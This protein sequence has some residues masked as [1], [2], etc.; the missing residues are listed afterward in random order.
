MNG[1]TTGL[2]GLVRFAAERRAALLL[3]FVL[4]LIANAALL[5]QPLVIG[6]VLKDVALHR[7]ATFH[8]LLLIGIFIAGAVFVG[9]GGY[10]LSRTG[11]RIVR[12]LRVRL[13]AQLL[14]LCGQLCQDVGDP[15]EVGGGVSK[16]ALGLSAAP[17]VARQPGGFLQQLPALLRP[18]VEDAVDL[19]LSNQ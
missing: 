13:G 3:A 4:T 11:E 15:Q 1:S 16:P 8:V 6:R 9:L 17:L 19:A 12:D 5:V 2:R 7:P 18:G 14:Q 10:V